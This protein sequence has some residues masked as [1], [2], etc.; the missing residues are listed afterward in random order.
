MRTQPETWGSQVHGHWVNSLPMGDGRWSRNAFFSPFNH[1]IKIYLTLCSVLYCFVLF[2]FPVSIPGVTYPCSLG[3][4]LKKTPC[5]QI[6]DTDSAFIIKK[7]T[8][9]PMFHSKQLPP[10]SDILTPAKITIQN[11]SSV[12]S[13]LLKA[14]SPNEDIPFPKKNSDISFSFFTSWF[15][16]AYKWAQFLFL[17]KTSY[18]HR[19]T[20]SPK[21]WD[22][23]ES[24]K[25]HLILYLSSFQNNS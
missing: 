16:L 7:Q 24:P 10:S 15:S 19:H 1:Q 13:R 18:F 3:P 14:Y 25:T 17:F 21:I 12:P 6:F 2:S 23:T 20:Y 22:K 8:F 5:I 9:F 11:I 4:P